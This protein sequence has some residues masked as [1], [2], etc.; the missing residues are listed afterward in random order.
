MMELLGVLQSCWPALQSARHPPQNDDLRRAGAQTPSQIQQQM[1][2]FS[3]CSPSA[4][5][6]LSVLGLV[7]PHFIQDMYI[8]TQQGT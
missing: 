6:H 8:T 2:A 4:D 7:T 5:A 3:A 1:M